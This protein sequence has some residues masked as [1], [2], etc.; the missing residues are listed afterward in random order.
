L[1][2]HDD[3]I[4]LRKQALF[5][6]AH[7]FAIEETEC[8]PFID[9]VINNLLGLK[10]PDHISRRRKKN[11]QL[12]MFHPELPGTSSDITAHQPGIYHSDQSETVQWNHKRG[13]HMH[14]PVDGNWY[15][16]KLSAFRQDAW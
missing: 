15:P 6:L 16:P 8:R 11:P 5:H 13:Q 12:E 3:E 7:Q 9:A 14:V 4:T 10:I 1:R 2:G